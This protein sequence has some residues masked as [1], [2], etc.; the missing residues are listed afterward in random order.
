MWTMT[1]GERRQYPRIPLERPCKI[2][3][4]RTGKYHSGVTRDLSTHGLLIELPHLT[5]LQVGD[6]IHVGIAM[7]RR[8]AL[9]QAA[10]M[11]NA[12]VVRVMLT[13]DDRALLG[14]KFDADSACNAIEI[15]AESLRLAA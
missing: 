10:N 2:H 14:V 1:E 3:D 11:I 9:L 8:Q 12:T 7:K 4:P 15:E 6:R 5:S 13:T